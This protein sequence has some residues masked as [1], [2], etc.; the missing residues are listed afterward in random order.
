MNRFIIAGCAALAVGAATAGTETIEFGKGKINPKMA[1]AMERVHGGLLESPNSFKGKIVIVDGRAE[2]DTQQLAAPFETLLKLQRY[3]IVVLARKPDGK[4][5]KELLADLKAQIGV[6]VVEDDET[7]H[8]LVAPEEGWA[9]VNVK[10]LGVGVE[11]S[12]LAPLRVQKEVVRAFGFVAGGMS[13][14]FAESLAGPVTKPA[15]LDGRGDPTLP[16]DVIGSFKNYLA[17]FGVTP[18]ERTNYRVACKAGWAPNPTNDVQRKVWNEVH[19]P[20]SN[21]IKIKY[22]P[23]RDK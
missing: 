4:K 18:Y 14:Q 17:A 12:R 23:K 2:A 6:I 1:E 8:L 11:K 22:D 3:N 10:N 7:P 21:P 9:K 16:Y 20:P 15:D 19:E 13:S 5:P